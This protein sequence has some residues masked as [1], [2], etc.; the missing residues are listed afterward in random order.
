VAIC[1]SYNQSSRLFLYAVF[2][3]VVSFQIIDLRGPFLRWYVEYHQRK[4]P[5]MLQ[6]GDWKY[7][8]GLYNHMV[9]YP[10]LILGGILPGCVMPGFEPDY[11]VPLAYQAYRLNMTF[12]SGYVSRINES[13]GRQ[14]CNGLHEKIKAGK[15]ES[16][17]IYVVHSQYWDLVRPHIPKIVCGWLSDYITCVLSVRDNAFR[18]FLEQHKLE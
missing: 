11:Y 17:T 1:V 8:T 12:N 14:Y 15:F 13:K 6:M 16:D 7:A 2:I 4:Q 10:P 18:G 9:L 5:F 3:A